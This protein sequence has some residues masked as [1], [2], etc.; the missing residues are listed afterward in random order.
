MKETKNNFLV[1]QY[2]LFKMHYD[3]TIAQVFSRFTI[4]ND[5]N[6]LGKSYTST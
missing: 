3:E 1:K 4:T 5:F 6:T 2:E